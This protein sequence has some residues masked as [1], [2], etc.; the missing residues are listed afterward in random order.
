MKQQG[1]IVLLSALYCGLVAPLIG[2]LLV[3][4][5]IS[6]SLTPTPPSL[7]E[8]SE[9]MKPET[10]VVIGG[11]LVLAILIAGPWA[12]L[13]GVLGGALMVRAARRS[14]TRIFRQLQRQ[15]AIYGMSCGAIYLLGIYLLHDLRTAIAPSVGFW[16]IATLITSVTGALCGVGVVSALQHR[17]EQVRAG[18][19]SR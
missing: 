5:A 19:S 7:A 12:A 8:M 9:L 16:S 13:F 4:L 2:G 11:S 1:K 6:I 17:L 14:D 15:A 18:V 10:F 3:L